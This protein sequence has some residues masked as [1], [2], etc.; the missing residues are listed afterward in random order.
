M[1]QWF[2]DTDDR[3][4][5]FDEVFAAKW[6]DYGNLAIWFRGREK[7]VA[8]NGSDADGIEKMLNEDGA[9]LDKPPIKPPGKAQI[10]GD[11]AG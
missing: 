5:K 3:R 11:G 4:V 2:T 1:A 6:D 7:P 9:E 10:T 8:F